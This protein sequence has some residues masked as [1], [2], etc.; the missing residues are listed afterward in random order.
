[1]KAERD[2]LGLVMIEFH[3]LFLYDR[4]EM[5]PCTAK[6]FYEIKT[7]N[8]LPIKKYPYK[9]P[10]VL[11]AEMKIQLDEMIQRGVITPSCSEWAEPVILVRKKSADGSPDLRKGLIFLYQ[12]DLVV[13]GNFRNVV[14][15]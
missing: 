2:V 12:R 13:A 4:F 10:L 9:V 7:G 3:D 6:S 8:A 14:V 5:L 11:R 1:V 15:S